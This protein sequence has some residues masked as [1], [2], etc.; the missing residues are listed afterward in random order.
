[1]ESK[2]KIEFHKY[3]TLKKKK[4]L[5]IIYVATEIIKALTN[6]VSNLPKTFGKQLPTKIY[7]AAS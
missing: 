6:F 3:Y 1:M 5:T 4:K 7:D 2:G